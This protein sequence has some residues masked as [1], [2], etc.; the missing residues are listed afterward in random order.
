[1]D[2]SRREADESMAILEER[3]LEASR[4]QQTSEMELEKVSLVVPRFVTGQAHSFIW[5]EQLRNI[6]IA[7]PICCLS[8]ACLP[9][10]C[11]L[12]C[13]N[14]KYL[15]CIWGGGGVSFFLNTCSHDLWVCSGFFLFLLLFLFFC[16]LVCYCCC[17]FLSMG[18]T[19]QATA[20]F[21]NSESNKNGTEMRFEYEF[22][23]FRIQNF[24][25][26]QPC[27]LTMPMLIQQ[28]A[29]SRKQLT[30]HDFSDFF[31]FFWGGALAG[32]DGTFCWSVLLLVKP[33][34]HQRQDELLTLCDRVFC[35]RSGCNV[36]K[37]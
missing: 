22:A 29:A 3:Q 37:D 31:F 18:G 8:K 33:F 26:S 16:L 12:S 2:R 35:H 7:V 15:Y 6:I 19:F 28:W 32:V 10:V 34:L 9:K 13:T 24:T 36:I 20:S 25:L 5:I 1:M 4:L 11:V 27:Q 23:S 21:Q 30:L 17:C 14:E